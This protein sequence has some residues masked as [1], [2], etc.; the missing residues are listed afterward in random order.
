MTTADEA[1]A[2]KACFSA[3]F[4]RPTLRF[5]YDRIELEKAG[6]TMRL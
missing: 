1:I 5:G 4:F 3:S 2:L 6:I